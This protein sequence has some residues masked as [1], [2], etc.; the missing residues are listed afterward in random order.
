MTFE[1]FLYFTEDRSVLK[2][3]LADNYQIKHKYMDNRESK[4]DSENTLTTNKPY[5]GL[6]CVCIINVTRHI[7]K[8]FIKSRPKL[9]V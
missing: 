8:W 7:N 5:S 9:C 1:L 3:K 6:Y 2:A 4:D